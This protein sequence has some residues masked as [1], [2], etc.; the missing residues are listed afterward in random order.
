MTTIN[1]T[2]FN[3][4]KYLPGNDYKF[5]K[6]HGNN[7][8]CDSYDGR[9]TEVPFTQIYIAPSVE[10]AKL[11][12]RHNLNSRQFT[13]ATLIKEDEIEIFSQV[14]ERDRKNEIDNDLKTLNDKY[15]GIKF[16]MSV[17]ETNSN[18]NDNKNL[19]L[20]LKTTPKETQGR[21]WEDKYYHSQDLIWATQQDIDNIKN[22]SSSSS[23]SINI[24]DDGQ[25]SNKKQRLNNN[26]NKKNKYRYFTFQL[27]K[28][29]GKEEDCDNLEIQIPII[30]YIDMIP[31]LDAVKSVLVT[32]KFN[33]HN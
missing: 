24:V 13:S 18:D 15:P 20:W 2:P 4:T 19:K 33:F 9:R 22:K 14:E 1:T 26:D 6:I 23:L 12:W 32:L 3:I 30:N 21:E 11:H 29:V 8:D 31:V 10:I 27:I 28:E 7:I 25:N 5:I 16:D 17:T